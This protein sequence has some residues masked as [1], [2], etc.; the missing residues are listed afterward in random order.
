MHVLERD[1]FTDPEL[2]H[3]PTPYCAA[4]REVGTVWREPHHGVVILSGI[5]ETLEVYADH[6]RFAAIVATLG[7]LVPHPKPARRPSRAGRTTA[8]RRVRPRGSCSARRP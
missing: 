4:L 8:P 1:F 2:L 6:E 5:E 3:D 7:P